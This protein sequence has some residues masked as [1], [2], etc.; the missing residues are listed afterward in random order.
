MLSGFVEGGDATGDSIANFENI[1]G[2]DADV[3]AGDFLVGDA[4]ANVIEGLKGNDTL[5]GGAGN[6]TLDGGDG[7]DGVEYGAATSGVTVSLKDKEATD[8]GF[9][10]QDKLTGIENV[11]RLPARRRRYEGDDDNDNFLEGGERQSTPSP[12]STAT[13]R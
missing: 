3:V 1:R 13:T 7:T 10:D 4:K 2:S 8:D 5:I 6:D 9:G 11:W 12:A